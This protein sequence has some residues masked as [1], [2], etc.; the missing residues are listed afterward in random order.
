M[1]NVITT[2]KT[3]LWIVALTISF[4]ACSKLGD[5]T[6]MG[7]DDSVVLNTNLEDLS[8]RM[9]IVQEPISFTNTY[10]LHCNKFRYGA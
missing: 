4:S 6:K 7:L 5:V 8:L 10:W 1:K 3:L 2:H 9:H